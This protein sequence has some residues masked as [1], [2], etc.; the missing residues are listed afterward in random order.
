MNW[1]ALVGFGII[2]LAALIMLVTAMLQGRLPMVFRSIRAFSLI[3]RLI[4]LAVEDGTRLHIS[5]GSGDILNMAGASALAGLT[6]L[7]RL[8]EIAAP[9]DRPPVVTTGSGV[10]N[11][12]AQDTLHSVHELAG[13]EA[14]FRMNDARLTG[15][16]PISYAAA[17]MLPI[18]DEQVSLNVILGNAGSEVGLMSEATFRKNAILISASDNLT[19]Q[20]VMFASSQE[21]LVGEELFAAGAYARGNSFHAASLLVQDVLRW[22]VIL[23]L[24]VGSGLKLLGVL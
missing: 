22:L 7:R 1:S 23:V 8:G 16:T 5:L 17:A 13:A 19:A 3:Q 11:L 4:R 15:L 9:G 2:V 12:L 24:L 6:L 18:Q 21:P 14:S 20:A 10:L